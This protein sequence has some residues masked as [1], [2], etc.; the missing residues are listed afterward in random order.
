[1]K[2]YA[3]QNIRNVVLLGSTKSG[4]TKLSE[5][6]L[7]EGKVIDRKGTVEAKNTVS[8]NTEF[9][10]VNQKSIFATPLYTEFAGTK[11]NFIDTAGLR[12]KSRINELYN[13]F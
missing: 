10:Q 13:I 8:D 6:M 4:K 2:N 5:A 1:M 3:N 7:Y 11:F 12:R 9:E